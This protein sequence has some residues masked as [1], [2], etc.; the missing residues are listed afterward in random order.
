MDR[1]TALTVFRNVAE[2]GSF[3]AAGRKLRLSPA[4]ISKNISE[5]EAHLGVRLINRTTRRMALTEEGRLYLEHIT[6]GLDIL[7]EADNA[8]SPIRSAPAGVLKVS[9]PMTVALTCLSK[10]IPKFLLRYPELKLD[11]HL[12][13]RRVDIIREGFDLAIRGSDSLENSS[14]IARKLAVMSHVLCASPAYFEKHGKPAAPGDLK[15]HNCVRFS[16]SG[17]ADFWEFTRGQKTIRVAV[18]ARYSVSSSLA[19][20]DALLAGFG[21][22]LI[23][24]PYVAADLKANRL[25]PA[26]EDWETVT[27]TLYAVYPSRQYVA[28]KISALMEFLIEVFHHGSCKTERAYRRSVS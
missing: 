24:Y 15:S 18:D 27:T 4:A 11:L 5:L 14:L 1:L 21:I 20:R 8:L 3:A 25:Q 2:S 26:L 9:A 23:P 12:D 16:L 10:A 7:A 28:P 17:H 13:D 19:V 6:R 22:S